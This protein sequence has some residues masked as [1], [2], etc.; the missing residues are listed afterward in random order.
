MGTKTAYILVMGLFVA[1]ALVLV[2]VT[3]IGTPPDEENH[4]KFIDYYASHSL[5]PF[6][7][8]QQPTY[9]LGD[10]TREVDYL[11][12][13]VMSWVERILP[14]SHNVEL[15]I[16]RL[17]SIAAGLLT[18]LVLSALFRRLGLS[19]SVIT[20]VLLVVTNIPM[21]L[22]LSSA[23]N[24]D[25]LVWLGF[26]LA[27]LLL[28]RL[29]QKPSV[30]DLLWLANIAI[31]GGLLKR[32]LLPFGMLFA[33]L[34][35]IIVLRHLPEF[36]RQVKRVSWQHWNVVFAGVLVIIGLALFSERVVYNI[37]EYHSIAPSCESVHG[38]AACYDFWANVRARY[39]ATQP[40]QPLIT[41]TT[42][43][44]RW[45]GHS[46]DNIVD[47]QT[48]GWRHEIRPFRL[49]TPLLVVVLAS[50]LIYGTR[51]DMLRRK[52]ELS[53]W[54]LY[55]AGIAYFGILVQL[56]V[57]YRS[58]QSNQVFGLALN[59][60]YILPSVLVLAGLCGFYWAMLLRKHPRWLTLGSVLVVLGVIIGSGLLMMLR[61]PQLYLGYSLTLH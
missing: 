21:V 8:D 3:S 23:I 44:V 53:R 5:D 34:G 51:F 56:A 28:V 58:Y 31:F 9:N 59:G 11:Y 42:F 1:Q 7:E 18:M 17:F 10:K 57:N 45:F 20:T 35:I 22:M 49:L 54:R 47:I 55:V 43:V 16:I 40:R 29:W 4:Y 19:A 52:A 26:S 25:A 48:Q 32:T 13:Y 39:L 46:F 30:V 24:N 36:R 2:S 15:H 12:H 50:G 37:A 6:F 60:R 41:P 38:D 27:L 33:V 61:N 14:F